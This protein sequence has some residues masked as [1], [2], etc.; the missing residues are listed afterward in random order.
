MS[1]QDRRINGSGQACGRPAHLKGPMG[2]PKPAMTLSMEYGSA[3]RSTS[4]HA[5]CHRPQD[6][7]RTPFVVEADR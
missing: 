7:L 3:P 4:M 1:A 5:A 2:M 6:T